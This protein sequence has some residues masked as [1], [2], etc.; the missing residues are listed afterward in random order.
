MQLANQRLQALQTELSGIEETAEEM[1]QIMAHVDALQDILG[2]TKKLVRI[3]STL[4]NLA[5]MMA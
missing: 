3:V 2:T 1:D 5:E 4:L